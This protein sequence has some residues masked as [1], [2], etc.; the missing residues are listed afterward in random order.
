M[1]MTLTTNVFFDHDPPTPDLIA[2][3]AAAFG[4]GTENVVVAPLLS[5]D[6]YLALNNPAIAVLWRREP[7]DQPGDFPARYQLAVPEEATATIFKLLQIVARQLHIPFVTEAGD[8]GELNLFLPDGTLR[9]IPDET[10]SDDDYA[11]RLR[12]SDRAALR[13]AREASHRAIAS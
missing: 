5:D 11:I 6:A 1:T 2:A 12:R 7:D 4:T 13:H 8:S 9:M 3:T 10:M